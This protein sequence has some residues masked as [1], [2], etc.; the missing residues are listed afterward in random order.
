MRIFFLVK[1]VIDNTRPYSSSHMIATE[2]T[3]LQILITVTANPTPTVEW[4]FNAEAEWNLYNF[5]TIFSNTTTNGTITSSVVLIDKVE[6]SHFGDYIFTAK[7]T[8]GTL[9]RRFVVIEVGSKFSL[10]TN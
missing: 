5:S 8:V 4:M 3:S 2:H 7:N 10:K 6:K 1:P 9:L